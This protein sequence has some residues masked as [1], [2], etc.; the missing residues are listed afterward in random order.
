MLLEA[1]VRKGKV[2][3]GRP[4]FPPIDNAVRHAKE[5]VCR[6][7]LPMKDSCPTLVSE[8]YAEAS[9]VWHLDSWESTQCNYRD[10][11]RALVLDFGASC[12]AYE[13]IVHSN[14]CGYGECATVAFS[15]EAV[16]SRILSWL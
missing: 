15:C 8:T 5:W 9:P 7:N 16:Y 4:S 10:S 14:L 12:T 13:Q 6:H 1:W 3:H 11:S 2:A